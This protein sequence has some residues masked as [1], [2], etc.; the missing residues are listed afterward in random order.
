M[1]KPLASLIGTVTVAAA[2]LFLGSGEAYAQRGGHGGGRGGGFHGGGFHGGGARGG[3]HGGVVNRGFSGGAYRGGAV[4][5]GGY[6]SYGFARPYSGYR[7]YSY[8]R[9][10]Y[11]YR[12][13]YARPFYGYGRYG[14]Y[15]PYYGYGGLFGYGLLGLLGYGGY[16]YGDYGYGDYGYGGY[17]SYAPDYSSYGYSYPYTSPTDGV[18]PAGYAAP[19]DLS[20]GVP[21]QP[22]VDNAIHLKLIVPADAEVFF[23]GAKTSQTGTVREYVSPAMPPGQTYTYHITVRYRGANGK[24]VEDP[25]DIRVRANDWFTVDFTRPAPSAPP[26]MPP[27]GVKGAAGTSGR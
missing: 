5:R 9:P 11:G 1:F 13:Y 10:Y 25:R 20:A 16:G 19:A 8:A 4:Y 3:F 15:R 17:G 22:P 21:Q 24:L 2:A 12:S 18:S 26:A 7:G 27:A 14:F 23:D 6:R